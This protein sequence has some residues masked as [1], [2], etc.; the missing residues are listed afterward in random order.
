MLAAQVARSKAPRVAARAQAEDLRST[1]VHSEPRRRVVLRRSD[2][3][4]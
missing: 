2:A 1:Q 3:L 4:A